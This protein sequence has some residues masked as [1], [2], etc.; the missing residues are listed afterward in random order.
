MTK[1]KYLAFW[2]R[3]KKTIFPAA[4]KKALEKSGFINISITKFERG[5]NGHDSLYS[6][7]CDYDKVE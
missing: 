5:I 6:S 3:G 7:K 1:D 2:N 4:V